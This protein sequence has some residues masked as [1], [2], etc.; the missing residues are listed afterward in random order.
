MAD[1]MLGLRT[2]T[3]DNYEVFLFMRWNI[4]N[5]KVTILSLANYYPS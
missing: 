5:F 4:Y 2:V 1:G 3:L